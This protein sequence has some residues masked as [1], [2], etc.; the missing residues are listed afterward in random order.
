MTNEEMAKRLKT[1]F[2]TLPEDEIFERFKEALAGVCIESLKEKDHDLNL[3]R[4]YKKCYNCLAEQF[5]LNYIDDKSIS[6]VLE[7]MASGKLYST[8]VIFVEMFSTG[9]VSLIAK[10]GGKFPVVE[11]ILDNSGISIKT[12]VNFLIS[13]PRR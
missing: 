4:H 1:M 11:N 12:W 10:D 8:W 6:A 5:I 9:I 2:N 3:S 13:L 7:D